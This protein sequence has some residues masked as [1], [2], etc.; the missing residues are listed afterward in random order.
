MDDLL[1]PLAATQQDPVSL[2]G[3]LWP[4]L[5]SVGAL[6]ALG[7]LAWLWRKRRLKLKRVQVFATPLETPPQQE[8]LDKISACNDDSRWGDV[9]FLH[10]LDGDARSTW[11]P[12]GRPQDFWPG[13]VGLDHPRLGVWSLQYEASSSAWGGASLPLVDRATHTLALLEANELGDRPLVFIGH[14]LGGLLTKQLLRRASEVKGNENWR[15][16]VQQTKGV[17]F[18]ATPHAG[19]D[20]ASWLSYLKQIL[21][22]TVTVEEL[23]A[24]DPHLRDLNE[25][26]RQSCDDLGI[27]TQVYRETKATVGFGLVVNETSSDPGITGVTPVP[28]AGAD[29]VTICK[30]ERGALIVQLVNQFLKRVVPSA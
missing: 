25:W 15:R 3:W 13:W 4:A 10:G 2:P 23:Q 21:R 30:P 5:G 16:I 28:V 17:V 18:L 20:Y 12:E 9:I 11:H 6:G 19:S 24:H 8:R 29:H 7:A 27:E 26:Y 22:L 14:S 1:T